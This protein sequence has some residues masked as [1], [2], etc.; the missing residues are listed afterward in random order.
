MGGDSR[1]LSSHK[2]P[3]FPIRDTVRSR[4]FPLVN[5][6]LLG[7]N[8]LVF[9]YEVSLGSIGLERFMADY[10]LIPARLS[11]AEPAS[12]IPLVTSMFLHGGW[13]HVISN[14]WTLMIFGDNV[15]DRMGS[16]RYLVFYLTAGIFAGAVQV[17][18]APAST[19]PT[20]GASGAIAAVLGAYFL[21]YPRGRILTFVPLFILP[22]FLE[23]PAFVYLGLW[24]LSQLASGLL[25][26]GSAGG[27]ASI[28]G[29]AWWA[30][31]G[32]FA[33]GLLLVRVLAR[34]QRSVYTS[35]GAPPVW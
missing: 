19:I 33:F 25:A 14:L 32:G 21:L 12:L 28:G 24:F 31:V 17:V 35:T 22:W 34:P 2:R 15:E 1:P 30:H 9:L 18:F 11:L 29:I 16:L 20:V 5:W 4:R 7:A 23:I 26:L 13:F 6:I 10:A 27:A 8:V 3:M